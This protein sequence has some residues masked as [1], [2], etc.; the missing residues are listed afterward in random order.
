MLPTFYLIFTTGWYEWYPDSAHYF[1]GILFSAGDTITLAVSANSTTS[2]NV[3]IENTSTGQSVSHILTSTSALCQTSAEWIVE[4]YQLG[5]ETVPL[6]NFGMVKFTGA[7]VV[8]HNG[9]L[10]PEG[11]TL[12]NMANGAGDVLADT[13]IDSTSV[14]VTYQ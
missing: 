4:D 10:G 9:V 5:G 6:A 12:I 14:T 13:Q 1:T 2:G 3:L 11:A 7:Q 8:A